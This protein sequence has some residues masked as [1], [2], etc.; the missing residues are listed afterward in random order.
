MTNKWFPVLRHVVVA[1]V[2]SIATYCLGS[3]YKMVY[4]YDQGRR[5]SLSI[6]RSSIFGSNKEGPFI[7]WNSYGIIDVVAFLKNG[8]FHGD[9]YE[10]YDSGAIKIVGQYRHGICTERNFYHDPANPNDWK[11]YQLLPKIPFN[12]NSDGWEK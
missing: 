2:V 1:L 8:E 12:A 10:W 9:Y 6:F 3:K 4:E 7:M 11:S 5:V